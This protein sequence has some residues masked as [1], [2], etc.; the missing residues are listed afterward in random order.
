[1]DRLLCIIFV[2]SLLA[3]TEPNKVNYMTQQEIDDR[4]YEINKEMLAD[5]EK[6]IG[7]YLEEKG[8]PVKE[9]GTG[10]R[11]HVYEQGEGDLAQTGQLALIHFT[12]SLLSGKECYTSKDKEP[13]SFKIGEADV[14]S[15]LHEGIT[16]MKPGDKAHLVIPSHLAHGLAGDNIKI[17]PKATIVYDVELIALK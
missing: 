12:V 3:C 17:P 2:F 4:L 13:R 7:I 6:A 8:W 11:V 10:L 9:T 5:E 14:E 16:Y 1:M 15:G